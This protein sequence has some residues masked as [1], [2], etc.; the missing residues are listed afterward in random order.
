MFDSGR[1]EKGFNDV[2]L[3][4]LSALVQNVESICQIQ[5]DSGADL[6]TSEL[7]ILVATLLFSGTIHF[8]AVVTGQHFIREIIFF[9]SAQP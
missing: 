4:V 8:K 3:I 1:T 6:G 5:K 9:S 7:I 2:G